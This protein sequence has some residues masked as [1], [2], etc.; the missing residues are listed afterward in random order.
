MKEFSGVE[1]KKSNRE[2]KTAHLDGIIANAPARS[3]AKLESEINE[4]S[5]QDH[6]F[7]AIA[8]IVL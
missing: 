5:E 8:A 1:W 4:V 7:I 3:S 2:S 6:D